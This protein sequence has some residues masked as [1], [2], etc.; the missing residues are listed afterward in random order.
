MVQNRTR[1]GNDADLPADGLLIW[2]VDARLTRSGS[3]F[4]YDNSYT[5]HKLL[6][7]MEA[8]GLEEIERDSADARTPRTTTWPQPRSR[9]GLGPARP[10]MTVVLPTCRLS[11]S[12]Q[13]ATP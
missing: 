9:T 12:P 13:P 4:L 11:I 8:D 1:P 10:V 3:D 7:L 6:R 2:H 5:A